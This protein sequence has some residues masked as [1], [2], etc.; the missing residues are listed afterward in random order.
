MAYHVESCVLCGLSSTV[1]D[2]AIDP[3]GREDYYFLCGDRKA[4]GERWLRKFLSGKSLLLEDVRLIGEGPGQ[5][6]VF[7]VTYRPQPDGSPVKRVMMPE[8]FMDEDRHRRREHYHLVEMGRDITDSF[9][10]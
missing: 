3:G 1:R 6:G 4:C 5:L 9:R 2:S 8:P 7:E 10:P